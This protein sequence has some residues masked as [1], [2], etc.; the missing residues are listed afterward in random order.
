MTDRVT[1]AIEEQTGWRIEIDEPRLGLWPARLV[2][3]GVR[4]F[5]G[6]RQVASVDRIEA[7]WRW[8]VVADAP[9]RLNSVEL[10]GVALDLRD[11]E[12][13]PAA[14]TPPDAAPVDPWRVVE[15]VE[16]RLAGGRVDGRAMDVAGT[17][18]GVRIAA[19]LVDGRARADVEADRLELE[20]QDRVL[21]LGPLELA[22]SA[23][24]DGVV[25]ERSGSRAR[26]WDR[27][28][29]RD[30]V[31]RGAERTRS[32]STG[33]AELAAVL[34]WWDPNVATGLSP[35]GVVDFDGG[36]ALD[37]DGSLTANRGAPRRPDP[38]RG[39]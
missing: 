3:T 8:T 31:R 4:V 30:Q 9:H 11:L 2:A 24:A 35:E 34:E 6:E 5:A 7:S 16:L 26:S 14:E 20:R 32:T 17:L 1:A 23:S 10:T 36:A 28:H 15:G 21:A 27:G 19:S 13:P 12:L 33:R 18:V 25:V 22:A 37:A 38:G 39:Y 29:R